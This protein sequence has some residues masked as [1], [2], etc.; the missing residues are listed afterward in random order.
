MNDVVFA[1]LPRAAVEFG[2]SMGLRRQRLLE[3]AG[4]EERQLE[5][6]DSFVD[7]NHLLA[8]WDGLVATFPDVPVGMAYGDRLP[9]SVT[10]VVGQICANAP[11]INE[12]LKAQ[13]RFNRL[14][15]PKLRAHHRVIDARHRL[16]FS[17]DL[18][19]PCIYEILEMLVTT[20]VRFARVLTDAPT[21]GPH[22][23]AFAFRRRH[24]AHEYTNR[25]EGPVTFEAGWTGIE[26]PAEY[27]QLP[28]PS[29]Q[30][31][32]QRYLARHAEALLESRSGDDNP[33]ETSLLDRVQRHIETAL[34]DGTP[35]AAQVAS[36]IGMSARTLQRRL[37][38][39]D[40]T[41]MALIETTRRQRAL[42]LL[43]RPHLTAQEV[44]FMLGYADARSFHRAF[45]RWTGQSPGEFRRR[46]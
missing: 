36:R 33:A 25:I 26:F 11:T 42:L 17:Y 12:A 14:L 6:P 10:G 46:D 9:L 38:A 31:D 16:E 21:T 41:L 39:Q 5:D 13:L 20:T 27:L 1:S 18:P 34:A 28:L 23:V 4:L 24:S 35:T 22:R 43:N 29:A 40:T 37:E 8:L 44:A 30:P 3:M 19:N 45:K 15:D 2:Q 32:A 7:Y